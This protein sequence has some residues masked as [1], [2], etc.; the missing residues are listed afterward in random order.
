M[1]NSIAK[2]DHINFTVNNLQESI[3]WYQKV[4]H[5]ELVE[6]GRSAKGKRWGILKSGDSMLAITEYPEKK[7]YEGEEFHQSYHFGLRLDDAKEW[8]EKIDKYQLKTYYM[9]PVKY[10]HSTSWY[11]KDPTGNEIE[12]AIWKNNE[13][14]F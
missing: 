10:P 4:F 13:I 3:T 12:V 2:L 7:V 5:F 9:S 11:V 1:K 8:Q 14:R 6:S